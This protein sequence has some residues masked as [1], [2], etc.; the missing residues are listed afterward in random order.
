[1]RPPSPA[2]GRRSA[3]GRPWAIILPERAR[4]HRP[5]DQDRGPTDGTGMGPDRRLPV[6]PWSGSSCRRRATGRWVHEPP[7]AAGAARRLGACRAGARSTLLPAGRSRTRTRRAA[8]PATRRSPCPRRSTDPPPGRK[9][10]PPYPLPSS[11][12]HA[13]ATATTRSQWG[14]PPAPPGA[15][16]AR[17]AP[18]ALGCPPPWRARNR[19]GS[20]AGGAP[21]LPVVAISPS[22]TDRADSARPA[23]SSDDLT[24][25]RARRGVGTRAVGATA[26]PT[27]GP[28]AL[29]SRT[30]RRARRRSPAVPSRRGA[31][32]VHHDPP[33]RLQDGTPVAGAVSRRAPRD[34]DP[35][36]STKG[37][38]EPRAGHPSPAQRARC[39]APPPHLSRGY[40]PATSTG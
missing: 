8:P 1:M 30:G 21:S 18:T 17:A 33:G 27:A 39:R 19:T 2:T 9:P 13:A 26:R 40:L 38:H 16:A 37:H 29:V 11:P 10:A 32:D 3:A 25:H 22:L 7:A 6:G 4:A 36:A 12:W 5:F 28:G 23:S 35:A 15:P 14:A 20:R 24:H 34:V 31:E